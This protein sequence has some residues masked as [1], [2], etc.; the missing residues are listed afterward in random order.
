MDK[1][2]ELLMRICSYSINVAEILMNIQT[3][4]D[5]KEVYA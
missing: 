4:R 2:S 5:S 1:M 3:H